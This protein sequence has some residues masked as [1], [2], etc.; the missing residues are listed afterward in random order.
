MFFFF[1]LRWT[2]RSKSYGAKNI[3]F[4]VETQQKTVK[5]QDAVAY[6]CSKYIIFG[7]NQTVIKHFPVIWLFVPTI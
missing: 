7:D 2:V 5:V 1:E 3:N 6:A 4:V